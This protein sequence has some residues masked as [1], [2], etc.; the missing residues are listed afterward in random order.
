MKNLS[1]I[2]LIAFAVI[3]SNCGRNTSQNEQVSHSVIEKLFTEKAQ[4]YKIPYRVLLGMALKESNLSTEPT[5][6]YYI[7]KEEKS[8]IPIAE[9]VFGISYTTIGLTAGEETVPS[10]P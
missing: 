8:S 6:T 5:S 1:K 9:S 10:K 2:F 7:N 4:Q 3:L